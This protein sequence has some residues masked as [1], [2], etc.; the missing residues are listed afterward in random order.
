MVY[1]KETMEIKN[2]TKY[3]TLTE[4][5]YNAIVNYKDADIQFKV[6]KTTSITNSTCYTSVSIRAIGKTPNLTKGQRE[7]IRKMIEITIKN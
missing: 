5:E 2:I 7:S 4:E 1:K 3:S 6:L